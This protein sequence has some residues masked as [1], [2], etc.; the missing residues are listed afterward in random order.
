MSPDTG[1]REHP[2]A[3]A[4]CKAGETY[5]WMKES[6]PRGRC[7][8]SDTKVL[9]KISAEKVLADPHGLAEHIIQ[10]VKRID[11]GGDAG[12]IAVPGFFC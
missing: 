3:H 4:G 5:L 8:N 10:K 12:D 1:N 2:G 6:L 7:L 11:R 9:G